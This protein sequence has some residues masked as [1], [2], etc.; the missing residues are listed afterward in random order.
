[1]NVIPLGSQNLS[2]S[3]TDLDLALNNCCVEGYQNLLRISSKMRGILSVFEINR[4]RP[5]I[6]IAHSCLASVQHIRCLEI[7]FQGST[8]YNQIASEASLAFGG[9]AAVKASML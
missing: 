2:K 9:I 5:R 6:F 7:N 4:I 8:P 1:M 3:T